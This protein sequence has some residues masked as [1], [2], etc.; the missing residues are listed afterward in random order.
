MKFQRGYNWF[1]AVVFVAGVICCIVSWHPN[2]GTGP[3]TTTGGE[4]IPS[5]NEG[6]SPPTE[7][8]LGTPACQS[9]TAEVNRIENAQI[10]RDD[11][12]EKEEE[13]RMAAALKAG[14]A[15]SQAEAERETIADDARK[16]DEQRQIDPA[17]SRMQAACNSAP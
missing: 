4:T 17:W 8:W 11:R 2:Q 15:A 1:V 7:K 12:V 14:E 5:V 13:R 16:F 10:D 9:A 6:S 3:N